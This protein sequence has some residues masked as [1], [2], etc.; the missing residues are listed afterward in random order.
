M[1]KNSN[2]SNNFE[3]YLLSLVSLTGIQ[4][5]YAPIHCSSS[6]FL[7]WSTMYVVTTH[8]AD[9]NIDELKTKYAYI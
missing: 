5:T 4:C 8:Q 2:T 9:S 1:C 3:G 7:D 6:G